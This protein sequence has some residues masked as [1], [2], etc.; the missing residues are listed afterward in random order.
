MIHSK[1]KHPNCMYKWM[2]HIISPKANAGVAEWF[3]RRPRTGRPATTADKNHCDTYHAADEEYFKQ[4]WYWTT[5]TAKCLT[6]GRR[7]VQ[8]LLRV[9]QGWT[10]VKG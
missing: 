9:V 5:P 4:V 10:E 1:S 2:N 7:A 6:A 8:G 3:G